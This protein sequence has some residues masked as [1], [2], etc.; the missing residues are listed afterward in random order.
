MTLRHG[1]GVLMALAATIATAAES[2][3]VEQQLRQGLDLA[4]RNQDKAAVE[5]FSRLVRDYPRLPEPHE[6]L[7]VVYL[8]LGRV[9]DAA[10]A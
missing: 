6:Q 7:A 10:A 1:A 4:E 3:T 9:S 8:R 5:I 2:I